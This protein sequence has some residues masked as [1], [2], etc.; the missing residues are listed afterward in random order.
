MARALMAVMVAGS[1]AGCWTRVDETEHCVELQYGNVV[2]EKMDQGLNITATTTVECFSLIDQNYP[3]NEGAETVEAVTKAP[4]GQTQGVRI[5]GD[6]AIVYAFNPETVY[7]VFKEKRSER[8][9]EVEIFNSVREGYRNALANWTVG[10]VYSARRAEIGDSVK[11]HIQRKVGNRATIKQAYIRDIR[12]PP[13]IEQA[14]NAAA[15]QAQALDKQ[16][17][18]FEID[19]LQ[20]RSRVMQANA[21]A[22]SKRLLAESYSANESLKEIEVARELAKICAN[23]QQCILGVSVM[24]RILPAAR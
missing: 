6:V 24:D 16:K 10:D 15:Q 1:L 2:T 13:E 11:A 20:A 9:A 4:P 8:A 14:R 21:E 23:A 19:S 17:Q 12:L 3:D 18:Q 5:T 7:D 22:E